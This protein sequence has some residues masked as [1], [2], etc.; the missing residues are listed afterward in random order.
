[1]PNPNWIT[2]RERTNGV[3]SDGYPDVSNRPARTIWSNFTNQ[4]DKT[5]TH[6]SDLTDGLC[7]IETDSYT[8][9]AT[10]NTDITLQNADLDIKYLR[11]WSEESAFF[12]Y[13]TE[14]IGVFMTNGSF[15]SQ[16]HSAD[17]RIKSIGTGTFRIGDS[18]DV[19]KNGSTYY[20]TAYGVI[21]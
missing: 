3:N 15:S 8:G 10:D 7:V 12:W 13:T 17:D 5:G 2:Y 21:A 9:N 14:E 16:G 6:K 4:H 11:I 20:F 18:D 19:N 1:M